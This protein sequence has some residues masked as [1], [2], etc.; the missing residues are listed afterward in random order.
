MKTEKIVKAMKQALQD[1]GY[2]ISISEECSNE[3]LVLE[4]NT[5]TIQGKLS[6]GYD[7]ETKAVRLTLYFQEQ[8][9]KETRS[10]SYETLN[11]INLNLPVEHFAICPHSGEIIMQSGYF[12]TGDFDPARFR[13]TVGGFLGEAVMNYPLIKGR[14]LAESASA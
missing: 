6:T 1:S 4:V 11:E 13:L 8:P 5:K 10:I 7:S 2:P 12:I 3:G 9:P 14:I